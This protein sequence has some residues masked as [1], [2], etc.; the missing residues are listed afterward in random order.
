[1]EKREQWT[2]KL[3]FILASAGAAIG[4][5]AIW[6]FPY[7]AGTS[8]GGAFFLIFIIFTV[9][10]GLPM[11]ISEY[12]IGRGTAKE[13]V[14][15]YKKLAPKSGWVWVGRLGVIGCFLLLSFYSVVGGWVLIYS[16]LSIPG[17]IISDGAQYDALF[18]SIISS[19]LTTLI[20]LLVFTLINVIVIALGVK[21]GIER[22]NKFMMPLLFIFFIILVVRAL[23]LP[24][25]WEGVVFFLAPDFSDITG[26]SV[27]FALGQSFFSLSVGFSCMVTYSSYL[28]KDVSL[29]QSAG[30]VVSMNI[31]VSFL[32][33]LAIFPVVFALG[34]DPAEGPPLLFMVLPAAFGEIPFGAF[35]LSLFLLL[36]LFATLTSSFSLYEIIVA[37]LTANGK[38]TRPAAAWLIGAI[39]FIAAIPSALTESYLANVSIFGLTIF[40]ATDFLVSNILLPLGGLLIALFIIHRA[41]KALVREEFMLGGV[42]RVGLYKAWRGLMTW[43][44]P[45]VIILV[46]LDVLGI[47]ALIFG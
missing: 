7:V 22:A 45:I 30:S 17:K 4:L 43:F 2:S 34:M 14:S 24:D 21:N 40:D 29:T 27:L 8:G 31:F 32:A 25:A 33:G 44:V 26:E 1:M 20:G 13:A 41:D 42:E 38:L 16:A 47:R 3:G 46:F 12:I 36:F 5:G 18:G 15:A 10:I 39:V 23:T 9:L 6:K 19:P 28:Q 37:A 11:L 35:F